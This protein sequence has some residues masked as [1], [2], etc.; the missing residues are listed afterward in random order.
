[1]KAALAAVVAVLVGCQS[2]E[3]TYLARP[4]AQ[5]ALELVDQSPKPGGLGPEGEAAYREALQERLDPHLVAAGP[6]TPRLVVVV[7]GMR[8][9]AAEE[10]PVERIALAAATRSP[11]LLALSLG[12]LDQRTRDKLDSLGYPVRVPD[13]SFT[14]LVPGA[15]SPGA[16]QILDPKALILAHPRLMHGERGPA[17]RLRAEAEAFALALEKTLQATF[18]WPAPGR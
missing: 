7:T 2:P 18:H 8:E 16:G 12:S 11:V 1:M 17:S 9:A 6:D 10:F 5:I 13:A 15:R 14:L 3:A 4:G